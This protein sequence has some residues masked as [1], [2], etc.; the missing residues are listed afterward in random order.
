MGNLDPGPKVKQ[1]YISGFTVTIFLK[2]LQYNRAQW[3]GKSDTMPLREKCF[4]KVM[5]CFVTGAQINRPA[6]QVIITVLFPT[7]KLYVNI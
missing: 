7:K 4:F 3:V 6:L 1:S 2:T 5:N